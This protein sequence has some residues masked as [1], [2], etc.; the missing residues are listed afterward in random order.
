VAAE[1]KITVRAAPVT[2]PL[3]VHHKVITAVPVRLQEVPLVVAE[4]EQVQ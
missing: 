2:L 1:H 3:Q 4:V